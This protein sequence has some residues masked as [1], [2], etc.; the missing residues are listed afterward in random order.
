MPV[1]QGKT[2]P[3]YDMDFGNIESHDRGTQVQRLVGELIDDIDRK[4][5]AL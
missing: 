1:L 5:G 3:E 2:R 4:L